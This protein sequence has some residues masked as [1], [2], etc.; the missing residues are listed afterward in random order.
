[1]VWT[2][3][4]RVT[5]KALRA[6]ELRRAR[7]NAGLT[8]EALAYLSGVGFS[9]IG[10]IERGDVEP[11]R[12]TRR[13]LSMALDAVHAGDRGSLGEGTHAHRP[14]ARVQHAGGAQ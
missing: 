6:D 5:A 1:M 12:G 8:R 11:T 3:E 4:H 13:L 10:R 14:A 7:E 9:T 2:M